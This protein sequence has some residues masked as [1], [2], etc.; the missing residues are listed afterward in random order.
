MRRRTPQ[1]KKQLSLE[2]DCRNVY[3]EA[4]H[5]ARKSIPLHKKLRNRANRHR[6]ESPL[7]PAPAELDSDRADAI[8]TAMRR[9]AP[10]EWSKVPD[11]PL[12]MVIE[13][14][15]QQRIASHGRKRK[16]AQGRSE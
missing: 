16:A 2:K 3:G 1:E 15:R 14:N 9:K 8:E 10:K 7:R 4:P 13:E 12:A 5:G 6:D 11:G